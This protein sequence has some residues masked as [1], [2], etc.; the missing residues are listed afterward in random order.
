[1]TVS[2]RRSADDAELDEARIAAVTGLVTN[3]TAE[4]PRVFVVLTDRQD[5]AISFAIATLEG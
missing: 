4:N 5:D 1:M 2:V 3:V